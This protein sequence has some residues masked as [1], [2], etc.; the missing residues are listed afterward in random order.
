MAVVFVS[1]S[2]SSA[3]QTVFSRDNSGTGLWWHD[4]SLPWF[5]SSQ[6][7][8]RPDNNISSVTRHNVQY[9]HNNNLSTTVNGT[10]FGLRTLTFASGN[11]SARTL[12]GSSGGGISLTVGLYNNSAG[13]HV[14]NVPIGVDGSTVDFAA[15]SGTLQFGSDFFLNANT[16]AFSGN[17]NIVMNGV[18][19]G[20]G[21]GFT[22]AG[23]GRIDLNGN[24]TFT[25]S[26][27]INDGIARAG[28]NNAFG[29]TAGGVSVASG[30]MI[31]LNN[32]ISIG[33]EALTLNGTGSSSSGALRS[34][35]SATASWAGAITLGSASRINASSGGTLTLSGGISGAHNLTVGGDGGN[36]T[37]SGVIGTGS[38]GLTKD[39]T[40]GGVLLLSAV[41]T[42]SGATAID[43]GTLRLGTANAI[44][45]S[46]PVTVASGAT[47]DLN[48]NA[49]SIHS[50]AGA[51]NVSLGNAT[52]TVLNGGTTHSGVISGTGGLTKQGSGA[53][54][55]SGVNTY[56]G[57][58]TISAGSVIVSGSANSSAFTAA[59]GATLAGAGSVGNAT[60]NGIVSP[61]NATG[62][63]ATLN[64]STLNLGAGGGYTFDISAA[65][66]TPGTA[67]DLVSASGA[68]NVNGSGTFTIYVTGNPSGFSAVSSYSWTIMS[69]ASVSGFNVARFAVNTDDFVPSLAGG[70]FSVAQSGNNI[71]LEF[72]PPAT[73]AISVQA[74]TLDFGSLMVNTTSSEQS[75][76]VSGINLTAN[77]VVTAPSGY[78][79]STTSGSG[80]GSSVNLVPSSG[81]VSDTTIYV[82]FTPTT[83]S[84]YSGNITHTSTGASTENKPVTGA[85]LA[86]PA[87]ARG[88]TSLSY[89]LMVGSSPSAQN[90]GVTN[91]G[92][93]TLHYTNYISYG[94]GSGWLGTSPST[95]SLGAAAA[96]QHDA[97]VTVATM[98]AGDYTGTITI[99]GNQ[100]NTAQTISVSLSLTNIPAP[101]LNAT[102]DGAEMV[103]VTPTDSSGR[104]VLLVYRQGSDLSANPV[105]GTTYSVGNS[106]GG[107][108]VVYKGS[109][110][111]FEH[112]VAS[113]VAHYYRA[114]MINNDHYSPA[115]SANA[116]TD[117]YGSIERVENFSYTNGVGLQ[118]RSGGQGWT[119]AWTISVPRT[120]V[121]A[122]VENTS[123]STFQSDWP[124]ETGN[125]FAFKTTN[126]STYAAFRSF[127]AVNSG[128]IYVA[129]LYRRQFSEG[130]SDGKFS[131]ISFFDGSTERTFVGERGGSG[132]DDIFGVSVAGNG[133]T[134]G[135]ANSF[136]AATEYLLIGRYDFNSGE[137]AGIYYTS[138]ASI[139][140]SEPTFMVTATNSVA[141]ING[142]RIASGASSGWN[143]E[144]HF[145][146]IRVAT[147]W[148]SL[149]NIPAPDIPVAFNATGG[150]L[151]N[152]LNFTLNA[153]NQPVV[154]V[155]N[156]TGTFT[157]PSGTPPSIGQAFAGGTLLYN[158]TSSP[159]TH[160]GLNAGETVYYKAFSYDSAGP[161]YSDGLT[162]NAVTIPP[163][164]VVAGESSRNF[165]GFTANWDASDSATSYR[166][167]VS[168][169]PDFS[170]FISGYNNLTVGGTS[171]S[172]TV[173]HSGP[174]FYRVRA[175]NGSGT[176]GNSDTQS[177]RTSI[178][179]GQNRDGSATP[180]Y[181]PSTIYVG[182]NATFGADAWGTINANQW[183]VRVVI[184]T[185]PDI[186][187][188][189]IR[190]DWTASFSSAEY[191]QNT[192]PRFTSAGTWY[193]GMQID[194]GS[195]YS[196]N[197]WYVRNLSTWANL[198]FSGTNSDLT[199][200]I[201]PLGNPTGQSATKDGTLP[202]EIIN[203]AWAK[204]NSKDV[205][206]VR[207]LDNAFTAPTPG[208]AYTAGNSIGGD[209]V[210]YK[211]N[212]TSFADTG[213][214]ADTT[215]YYRFYSEN[216]SYYSAGSD[217]S[218]T[219]DSAPEPDIP[220]ATAATGIGYTLFTANWE[221]AD[222]A[223]SY[224]L[225]VSRNVGFTDLVLNNENVGNVLT[226]D[227]TGLTVGQYYYRVR[228][229][230][231][232]GSSGNSDT[233]AVGTLTAQGRNYLAGT[234]D[235]T[236][237]TIYLGDTVVFRANS[238]GIMPGV[239]SGRARLWLHTTATIQSGTAGVWAPIVVNGET[240]TVTGRVT[241]VGT[242]YWGMQYEYGAYGTNIWYTRDNTN[243]H[244]L[245]YAG[246]GATLTITV[247]ALQNPTALNAVAAGESQID[248]EWSKWNS[249]DVMVVRST[250][251]TFGTPTP[252]TT[253]TVGNT[254]SGDTVVY[255]G[256]GTSFSDTGLSEST[257]YYYKFYS[258]N[259]GY[260]SSG[261]V[262]SETTDGDVPVAPTANAASSVLTTS[263]QANWDAAA[264]ATSYRL[265]VS[266]VNN[267]SSFVSGYNNL[268][269]N[270]TFRSV[271]GLS[272]GQTYYYR[273]RG[274]NGAGDSDNSGTISVTLPSSAVVEIEE[275]PPVSSSEGTLTWSATPQ[276]NYDVYYSD[277]DP[278]GTMTWH[279]VDQVQAGS[280]TETI[281][282][283]EDDRRYFKVV[284]AGASP[285]ASSSPTWGVIKPTIPTGFSMFS[286]PLNG[287]REIDGEFGDALAEVMTGN[288]MGTADK[289]MIRESNGSWR[290]IFLNATPK[291][292]YEGASPVSNLELAAGQGVYIY[293]SGAPVTPRFA[294]P[295]GNTGSA[296]LPIHTGWN[297]FGPSQ[298]KNRTFNQV[299]SSFTGTPTAG[300]TDTTADLIVI[301]EGNG[302]WR[303]IMRYAGGSPTWL[304]L[305]TFSSPSITITPGQAVYYFRHSGGALSIN[306]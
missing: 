8:N 200:T 13:S 132:N 38:G 189:G 68:I 33:S 56:N 46:S 243:W 248:L 223:T 204:W 101:G 202:A 304:D 26:A 150:S 65:S 271:T 221:A 130:A 21:G 7:R 143:G 148:K 30:A 191:K 122:V 250:D 261:D 141:S 93:T 175:V 269:V 167:D 225:D 125:R 287:N 59:S 177:A 24:N 127:T 90:F 179:Q 174:Y 256:A 245:S 121:D 168:S 275:I 253:Y 173:P 176:S 149:L 54:T 298:G 92:G 96:Q 75:Y 86:A 285:T 162:A 129:A 184:D 11:S 53:L 237:S 79:V 63:R 142:I 290:T 186:I 294:G 48:N 19:S 292:W 78:Q 279:L 138:A 182:D 227:V 3:Q 20:S 205:L 105:N 255:K 109:V 108:T 156:S 190:G 69:G 273:V 113:G 87:I 161:A 178:V 83:V 97:T 112:V 99:N 277:S 228:G 85:G 203:L 224:R 289:I 218:E 157:D 17:N 306:F 36:V 163:A 120:N 60:I 57:A 32:G 151:Q 185:D 104:Q 155:Y 82:R 278:A 194:Y 140:S 5:Y 297:I 233:I 280:S 23:T 170:T 197:F 295:V 10:F 106:L 249:R 14:L 41:N 144:V 115:G 169:N 74:G 230:N 124:A 187:A 258:E 135:A 171:Q 183:K 147:S 181:T 201:D 159:Q 80:F 268:T 100:T 305:K 160:S 199:V 274:S 117:S 180:Y 25:G 28:H 153:A 198:Q 209:L 231:G 283:D 229:A 291:Q 88:P 37:I 301:D 220:V 270:D 244:N 62:D 102:A 137:M 15:S 45:D 22:K 257:T 146:E 241:S 119:S 239:V 81:T 107:G 260:Y 240:K 166:L 16:A 29:S 27:A 219:T 61:G 302:N 50:L 91:I 71:V 265:D 136:P 34:R 35:T 235:F 51:G 254:I 251:A 236:P 134:V 212:G 4:T 263:F 259:F 267:F 73:P 172:V 193:W 131:G 282:V 272:A 296:S 192:S 234:P 242:V 9:G 207:S 164:P 43:S 214:S 67:W 70:T 262:V 31:E 152:T 47:F 266:T 133:N 116:T 300:W 49:D 42:Y 222:G 84:S 95:A 299:V 89:T 215:Y 66:G 72:T 281:N 18:M 206:I 252:G 232:A 195:P 6:N 188:G 39:G 293:R 213:L 210:V 284:I 64:V 288:N 126:S 111:E 94:S 247:N 1:A 196:T 110:A 12:T 98:A 208:Q 2:E 139:P 165:L 103:R 52:L 44:G 238:W 76:I 211:G 55:L 286:P 216:F 217:A 123:F 154:I 303:R 40:G 118:T 246:T 77:I 58:S 128:R 276:A 264:G 158:G 145:D 226:Y 114:Y